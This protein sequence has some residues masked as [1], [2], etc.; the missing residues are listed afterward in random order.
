VVSQGNLN[1][2]LWI[3]FRI[4]RFKILHVIG[5]FPTKQPSRKVGGGL[6]AALS[7]I[8][9]LNA[10]TISS[11]MV[12]EKTER[13]ALDAREKVLGKEQ[14]DTLTSVH[15]LAEVLRSQGKYEVA[16]EIHRRALDGRRRC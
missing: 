15:G 10:S 7:S 13:E 14:P 9:L 11:N 2:E 1:L 12:A 16:E 3:M 6:H 4:Y 5:K 8:P